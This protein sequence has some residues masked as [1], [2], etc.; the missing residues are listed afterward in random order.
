M[1]VREDFIEFLYIEVQHMFMLTETLCVALALEHFNMAR[2]TWHPVVG[3][4]RR[5]LGELAQIHCIEDVFF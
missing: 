1:Q 3:F 4:P 5:V 2:Q